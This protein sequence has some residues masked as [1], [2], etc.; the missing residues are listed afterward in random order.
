MLHEWEKGEA[1][2]GFCLVGS[3]RR[4]HWEDRC[5]WEDNIKMDFRET[6]IDGAD[7]IRLAQDRVQ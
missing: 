3:K 2:T 6:E 5:R 7:W 1:F 4:D